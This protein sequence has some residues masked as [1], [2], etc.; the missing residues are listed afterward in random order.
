MTYVVPTVSSSVSFSK[1]SSD[2]WDF[3][4]M[5]N[6]LLIRYGASFGTGIFGI[7]MFI[8]IVLL[9]IFGVQ[10]IRQESVILPGAAAAIICTS[11]FL[12][13]AVPVNMQALFLMIFVILPTTGVIFD[14][15]R[16]R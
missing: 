8:G 1:W 6:D 3:G 16:K 7:S 12:Y 5:L 10:A 11:T 14:I 4:K 9:L 13:G 2:S 15:Y